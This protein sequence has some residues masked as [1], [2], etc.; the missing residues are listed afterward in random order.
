M[1]RIVLLTGSPRRTGNSRRMADSFER[2]AIALGHEVTRFD[3]AE[4]KVGGCRACN[5]CYRN[6]KPCALEEGYN[7][8]AEALE[9]ADGLVIAT[10]VYWYGFPAQ[11]KSVTDHWYSLCYAGRDLAGKR[12]A[13]IACCE[14]D[15]IGAFDAMRLSLGKSLELLKAELVG[16]VLVQNVHKLGDIDATD[17]IARAAELAR[18]F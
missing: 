2:S 1:S 17:G 7:A 3:T 5:C 10:P 4:M 6:G 9:T 13:L 11:L 8:V 18:L 15:D 14:D 16:E 12:A